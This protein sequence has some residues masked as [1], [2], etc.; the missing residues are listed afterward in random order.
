MLVEK[1][2]LMV[3]VRLIAENALMF[4]SLM[5]MM[6]Q[7][8]FFRMKWFN[9]KKTVLKFQCSS[10][11]IIPNIHLDYHLDRAWDNL[12]TKSKKNVY[13][14]GL[15]GTNSWQLSRLAWNDRKVVT[16]YLY[17]IHTM[18][19]EAKYF[20]KNTKAWICVWST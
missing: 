11:E 12:K 9:F 2:Y 19:K 16:T 4:L 8:N 7:V 15:S 18:Y 5:Q 6:I 14:H 1:Q 20:S 17:A 3:V 13:N 10:F